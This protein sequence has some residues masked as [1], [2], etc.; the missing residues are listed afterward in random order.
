MD[1][2]GTTRTWKQRQPR[3]RR[4]ALLSQKRG[5]PRLAGDGTDQQN[6]NLEPK[7]EHNHAHDMIFFIV[8]PLPSPVRCMGRY[9]V[10]YVEHFRAWIMST[11]KSGESDV[12][13]SEIF[14]T[15]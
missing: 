1:G 8:L 14:A 3:K 4:L 11:R 10:V 2:S 6:V 12:P 15:K 13:C 5:L 7:L 9:V